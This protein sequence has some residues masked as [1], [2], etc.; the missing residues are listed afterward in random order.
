MANKNDLKN[1][2]QEKITGNKGLDALIPEQDNIPKKTKTENK[3]EE[4]SVDN[5]VKVSIAINRKYHKT[6]KRIAL[7][8]DIKLI[9]VVN[10]AIENY[11]KKN[12]YLI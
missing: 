5:V 1:S 6:L 7:D 2:I 10:D 9:D 4:K 3:R 11:L 8:N 12:G